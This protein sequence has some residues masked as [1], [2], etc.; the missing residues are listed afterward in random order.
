MTTRPRPNRRQFL[1]AAGLAI[2]A[3]PAIFPSRAAAP[4]ERVR[5]AYI[6]CGGRA[7]QIMPMFASHPDADVVAVSDVN[8]PRMD[9][10]ARLLATLQN[11]RTPDRILDYRRILDRNDIDAVIIAT[12]QHWHGLPH[13][14]AAQAKKHIFVEKPLSHTVVEGRAMVQATKRAG[15]LAMMGTQQRAGPHYQKV[16]QIVQSGRLGKIALVQCWNYHNTGRRTGRPPDGSPPAGLNW[17]LWLGPAPQVPYNPA[18]MD[19]SWWFDYGGG[20]MTNWAIHHID[21]ILWAMNAYVPRAVSCS[22]GKYVVDDLADT[23]DTIEASWEFDGW[24]MQYSYRG[25]SNFHMF[26]SR[27]NHHGFC[28]HGNKA[29]L[30]VDRFGYEI[31]EDSDPKQVGEKVHAVPYFDQKDPQKSEQDGPWHRLFIDCVK[32][33]KQ[34]PVELEQSHKS[35]VCCHLANIA[36][37]IGRRIR[38]NGEAEAI[39]GDAEASAMLTKARRKGFELPNV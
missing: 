16:C 14:H 8:E 35:T 37:R 26:Q 24:M 18:R 13:I 30:I 12:T 28:F 2:A 5:L 19:N 23:P 22:G 9:Q 10:A 38:W 3:G 36:Y 32:T 31:W 15:V 25:F 1:T 6:G 4:S 33:L 29:S 21:A 7:R 34:P 11:G 17:D 39:D 20:M 27:P